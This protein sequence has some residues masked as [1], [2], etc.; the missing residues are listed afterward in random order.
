MEA[1]CVLLQ[2]TATLDVD[3]YSEFLDEDHSVWDDEERCYYFC[4]YTHLDFYHASADVDCE[5]KISFSDDGSLSN[6]KLVS[7]KLLNRWDI[8]LDLEEAK[9][10]ERNM[11]DYSECE[12]G[13]RA[14]RAEA[15][16]EYYRH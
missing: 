16:E 15:Q 11:V 7:T 2:I 6:I 5:V 10:E 4:A 9:I 14:E 12:D 1:D 3:G 13:Y 8:D